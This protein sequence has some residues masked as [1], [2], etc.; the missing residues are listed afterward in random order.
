MSDEPQSDKPNGEWVMPEPVY[1]SSP[2]RTPKSANMADPADEI[3]TEPGFSDEDNIDTLA[4]GF[5]DADDVPT[6]RP[7]RAQAEPPRKKKRG[8]AQSL[9]TVVGVIALALI[10]VVI[11]VVYFLFYYRSADNTF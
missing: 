1:R 8:C 3:P 10:G 4:P 7:I 6:E 11:A 2:G 5:V 9:L